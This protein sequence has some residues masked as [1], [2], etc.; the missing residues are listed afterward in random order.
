MFPNLFPSYLLPLMMSAFV[1]HLLYCSLS[2]WII[3]ITTS[4]ASL[5][6]Y[7]PQD[8]RQRRRFGTIVLMAILLSPVEFWIQEN[9][10]AFDL[11]SIDRVIASLAFG[12]ILVYSFFASAFGLGPFRPNAVAQD[13]DARAEDVPLDTPLDE[14]GAPYRAA[15][16]RSLSESQV[17]AETPKQ[18][19]DHLSRWSPIVLSLLGTGLFGLAGWRPIWPFLLASA[20]A[21]AIF[22]L[23]R[24][25]SSERTAQMAVW[26]HLSVVAA[27][28]LGGSVV[29]MIDLSSRWNAVFGSALIAMFGLFAVALAKGARSLEPIAQLVESHPLKPISD[30]PSVDTGEELEAKETIAP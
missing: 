3:Y 29:P 14:P 26:R 25:H 23:A 28:L 21:I 7:R 1:A 2:A 8:K 4:R 11:H 20:V 22:D 6:L 19:G 18:F 10:A 30:D 15:A 17:V 16:R 27:L 9:F 24:W 12:G 5:L 13:S